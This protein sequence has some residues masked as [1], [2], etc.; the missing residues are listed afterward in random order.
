MNHWHRFWAR[1]GK[2]GPQT[3]AA[4]LGHLANQPAQRMT[5]LARLTTFASLIVII[6]GLLGTYLASYSTITEQMREGTYLFNVSWAIVIWIAIGLLFMGGSLALITGLY[7]LQYKA[8]DR[9]YRRY[10]VSDLNYVILRSE[11]CEQYVVAFKFEG[12]VV[13]T[14]FHGEMYDWVKD[15]ITGSY[16][17]GKAVLSGNRVITFS[18]ENDAF[19]FK[20]RWV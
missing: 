4:W 12:G 10:A 1:F 9:T 5:V 11:I 8:E 7:W 2:P 14:A 13:K 19:A 16:K 20:M 15:N 6:V 18:D 17:I 3:F